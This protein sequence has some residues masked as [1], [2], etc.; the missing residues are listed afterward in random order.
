ME[1]KLMVVTHKKNFGSIPYFSENLSEIYRNILEKVNYI[2]YP[3]DENNMVELNKNEFYIYF[4]TYIGGSDEFGRTYSNI[5]ST[6]FEYPLTEQ[7]KIR[8]RKILYEV[9]NDIKTEID[10]FLTKS[11]FTT[12]KRRVHLKKSIK[13]TK[14]DREEIEKKKLEKEN[15]IIETEEI[16]QKKINKEIDEKETE[17]MDREQRIKDLQE[18][19]RQERVER[20]RMIK[21]KQ[22]R[23]EREKEVE[24]IIRKSDL[25]NKNIS[26]IQGDL[27]R[28][29]QNSNLAVSHILKI[30]D[31]MRLETDTV[32]PNVNKN[33]PSNLNK[34]FKASVGRKLNKRVI[35]MFYLFI[36]IA[37]LVLVYLFVG[38]YKIF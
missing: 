28:I 11:Y 20:K 32:K 9:K 23:H 13:L 8:V 21:I 33:N 15:Q 12:I 2:D 38:K 6:L 7:E 30:I 19:Y 36:C 24:Q 31:R 27:E 4:L 26:E 34:K 5:I 35:V 22:K 1:I 25:L 37:F 29:S 10:V 16:I 14:S 3:S 17:L 18:K